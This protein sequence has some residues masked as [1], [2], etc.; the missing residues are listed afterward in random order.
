MVA[1][2]PLSRSR[3]EELGM[4]VLEDMVVIFTLIIKIIIF[5]CTIRPMVLSTDVV[6]NHGTAEQETM[7]NMVSHGTA[8]GVEA[9]ASDDCDHLLGDSCTDI[10]NAAVGAICIKPFQIPTNLSYFN[11]QCETS[12]FRYIW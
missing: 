7:W 3:L 9:E 6:I 2:L 11:S 5:R 12:P 10:I 8:G 1:A 4:V